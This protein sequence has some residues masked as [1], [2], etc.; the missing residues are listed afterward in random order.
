MMKNSAR[1]V[2]FQT[3]LK[4]L[5]TRIFDCSIH[6]DYYCIVATELKEYY[7]FKP[8]Q[9]SEPSSTVERT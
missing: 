3:H 2:R 6:H 9:K 7:A 4:A 5:Q 1:F 8:N